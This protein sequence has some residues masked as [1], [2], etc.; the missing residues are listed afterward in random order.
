MY[1]ISSL[2]L[3]VGYCC[4]ASLEGYKPDISTTN[5][6][7]LKYYL[8]S[9]KFGNETDK[10]KLMIPENP[11]IGHIN[12]AQDFSNADPERK[13]KTQCEEIKQLNEFGF[14]A[15][16]ID[17]KSYFFKED[18]LRKKLDTIGGVWVSG[19]NTFILRQAMRL[20]GFDRIITQLS[21][22]KDF[23]YAG[24]S[25]GICILSKSLNS[26]H[27]VDDPYEFPYQMDKTIWE[28]LGFFD[29]NFI[30]HYNSDHPESDDV[31][32]AIEYCIKEK[33]LFKALKDGEVIIIE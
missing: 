16:A 8:S 26:L 25:A 20:S 23:L 21:K 3:L 30:P 10:L 14:V 1:V 9:Y 28:G 12:N 33:I 15:E 13:V 18:E 32:K 7:N 24:Y 4:V 11:K 2:S 6:T 17:L 19:G 27:I 22:R 29:Y 31:N 5:Y